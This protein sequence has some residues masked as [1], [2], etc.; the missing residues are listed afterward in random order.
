MT[1]AFA[2]YAKICTQGWPRYTVEAFSNGM[3]VASI[4]LTARDAEHM[5]KKARKWAERWDQVKL[6]VK[7]T[8]KENWCGCKEH[9]RAC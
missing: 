2:G 6:R 1:K 3:W 7:V 9:Y 8:G 5:K 4:A